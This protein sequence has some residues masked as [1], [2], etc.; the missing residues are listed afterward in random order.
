MADGQTL[1]TRFSHVVI[2]VSDIDRAVAFYRDTLG[3]DVVFDQELSGSPFAGRAAGGLLGGASIEL[4][5][6]QP[7]PAGPAIG[8]GSVGV[9]LISLSVPDLAA[10][11]RTLT[12]AAGAAVGQPFDV[13]GVR[14]F[15]VTD[16]DGTV[17]EFVEYPGAARTPAELHRGVGGARS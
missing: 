15:F 8:A 6:L 7:R 9:Q 11:H 5:C 2:A 1:D 14:M 12:D 16:P 4:L 10:T 17:I 3:M 13:D